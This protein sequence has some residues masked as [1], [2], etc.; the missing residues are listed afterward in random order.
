MTNERRFVFHLR[1]TANNLHE[2]RGESVVLC[3]ILSSLSAASTC[4]FSY[5][6]EQRNTAQTVQPTDNLK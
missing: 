1:Q 3:T 2:E 6:D 5:R 4:D